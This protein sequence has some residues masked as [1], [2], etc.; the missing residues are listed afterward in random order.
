M[1]RFTEE[2]LEAMHKIIRYI[3]TYK[4]RLFDVDSN[5]TDVMNR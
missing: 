1:L 5:L 3:R 2:I 4:A